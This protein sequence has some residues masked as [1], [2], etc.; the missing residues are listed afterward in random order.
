VD[1]ARAE[2]LLISARSEV[3]S[4]ALGWDDQRF[5]DRVFDIC[6]F[7]YFNRDVIPLQRR[8]RISRLATDV[9]GTAGLREGSFY[10][11][12]NELAQARRWR[13][14]E[15][16]KEITGLGGLDGDFR[17]N[18]KSLAGERVGAKASG[19]G[20]DRR[21]GERTLE[22]SV[23]VMAVRLYCEAAERPGF[24]IS[25]PLV[26]FANMIGELVLNEA[27]PFTPD[28]VRKSYQRTKGLA[29]RLTSWTYP[30]ILK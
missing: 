10:D 8:R 11:I 26:R 29:R 13:A 5:A 24:S 28:A 21:S 17:H 23:L 30:S 20:G 2:Q 9:L 1:K 19:H 14:R 3:A 15:L 7:A 25:G 16:R 18:L 27:R 6:R 4:F 12:L 22:G